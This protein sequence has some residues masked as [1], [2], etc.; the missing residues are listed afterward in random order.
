[1][2]VRDAAI[3]VLQ[4]AGQPLHAE[5]ITEMILAKGLWKTMGK[6]P[7]AT[8]SA[9]LYSDI[10]KHGEASPFILAT[11]PQ[12]PLECSECHQMTGGPA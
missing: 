11:S 4:E 10:K 5:A 12:V 3:Q 9:R 2:S 1:M 8:V 6:T 7:A